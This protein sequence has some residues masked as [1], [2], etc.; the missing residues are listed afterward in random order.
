MSLGLEVSAFETRLVGRL[1]FELLAARVVEAVFTPGK[2][3]V[4]LFLVMMAP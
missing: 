2:V 4:V 3:A 1:P